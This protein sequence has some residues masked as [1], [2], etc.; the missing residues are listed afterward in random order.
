MQV[1]IIV[2]LAEV[3]Q[4]S[5]LT[6]DIMYVLIKGGGDSEQTYSCLMDWLQI[7]VFFVI[8]TCLMCRIKE[9][10]YIRTPLL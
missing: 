8:Q 10:I 3:G 5:A 1:I 4:V 6:G 7:H 9:N 2:P